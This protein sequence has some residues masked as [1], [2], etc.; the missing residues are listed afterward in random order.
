MPNPIEEL[1]SMSVE[2]RS[3]LH[4]NDPR[5]NYAAK[6]LEEQYGLPEGVLQALKFAE[7]TGM[8]KKGKVSLSN[9]NS[10]SNPS[11]AGAEGIMQFMPSTRKLEWNGI[12]N[13]FDHNVKDPMEGLAAAARYVDYGMEFYKGNIAA[14]FADY[15]G[16]PKQ[17]KLVMKGKKP[18]SE[19]TFGYLKKIRKYYENYH[20]K[21]EVTETADVPKNTEEP[22][23]EVV[24]EAP[25]KEF[26]ETPAG[27][28]VTGVTKASAPEKKE[29]VIKYGSDGKR[30]LDSINGGDKPAPIE[31]VKTEPF[32]NFTARG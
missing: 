3:K 23:K 5:L 2:Q 11:R 30:T 31:P 21:P 4:W 22:A 26:S 29:R 25:T 1:L 8:D 17:A 13:Y 14:I 7:N 28:A 20:N 15:N 24:A 10:L 12:K 6:K 18:N 19:E 9:R 32:A 16:G 27:A